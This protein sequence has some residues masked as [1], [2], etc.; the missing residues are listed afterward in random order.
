[1]AFAAKG[2]RTSLHPERRT[3]AQDHDEQNEGNKTRGRR[4][5]PRVGHRADYHEQYSGSNK[6]EWV[7]QNT[8]VVSE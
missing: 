7:C 5:V 6:L 4:A 3:N 2:N 8:C 1:M